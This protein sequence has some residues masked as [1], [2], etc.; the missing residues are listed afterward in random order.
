MFS[1]YTLFALFLLLPLILGGTPH[2]ATPE[3]GVIWSVSDGQNGVGNPY[4]YNGIGEDP[5]A[6][7]KQDYD[8]VVSERTACGYETGKGGGVIVALDQDVILN[9][10]NTW[11]GR[12]VRITDPWGKIYTFSGGSLVIGEA[13]AGCTGKPWID[14]SSI[15]NTEIAGGNCANQ[16]GLQ[17]EG[18]SIPPITIEVLEN[19][20]PGFEYSGTESPSNP[21]TDAHK[22]SEKS[23]NSASSTTTN[24]NYSTL[25]QSQNAGYTS[26]STSSNVNNVSTTYS[27]PDKSAY[28]PN[29]ETSTTKVETGPPAYT[30]ATETTTIQTSIPTYDSSTTSLPADSGTAATSQRGGRRPPGAYQND[31]PNVGL[32]AE[33][34]KDQIESESGSGSGTGRCERKRRRS[35]L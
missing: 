2:A 28:N 34:A 8:V 11:C 4:Y 12:E 32:F 31:N 13:C 6:S 15:V 9:D 26:L 23:G 1:Y 25:T 33:G 22:W 24:N 30:S 17:T 19:V 29:T 14:L 21:D 35:R 7:V 10:P 27:D 20:I 5:C 3:S 16:I 18:T